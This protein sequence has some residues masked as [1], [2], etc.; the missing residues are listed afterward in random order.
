MNDILITLLFSLILFYVDYRF[1]HVKKRT[2]CDTYIHCYHE[3]NGNY[4]DIKKKIIT[5][6][7]KKCIYYSTPKDN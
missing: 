3:L 4:C 2:P 5:Q 7:I 6:K 1:K